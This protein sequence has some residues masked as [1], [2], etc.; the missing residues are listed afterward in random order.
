MKDQTIFVTNGL[1]FAPLAHTLYPLAA[2]VLPRLRRQPVRPSLRIA[3]SLLGAASGPGVPISYDPA[4]L[5]FAEQLQ[6]LP[7]SYCPSLAQVPPFRQYVLPHSVLASWQVLPLKVSPFAG[8]CGPT[9]MI[10]YAGEEDAVCDRTLSW[11]DCSPRR[12]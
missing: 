12:E 9:A 11:P 3:A 1:G 5:V 10:C 2:P 6:K 4:H 7:P 8:S